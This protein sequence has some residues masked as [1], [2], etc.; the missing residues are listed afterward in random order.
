MNKVQEGN[1]VI[2]DLLMERDSAWAGAGH[3]SE[4]SCPP[5]GTT[6]P[7]ASSVRVSS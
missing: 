7:P 3:R 1:H 6:N 5:G 2:G 4:N